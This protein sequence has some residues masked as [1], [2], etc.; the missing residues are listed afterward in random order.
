MFALIICV[1][2]VQTVPIDSKRNGSNFIRS[3][4]Q[5]L[6]ES[7]QPRDLLE[8]ELELNNSTS[9]EVKLKDDSPLDLELHYSNP[10]NFLK[11]L[12]FTGQCGMK[13]G[14]LCQVCEGDCD[15]D[16]DCAEGLAC[17]IRDSK[18]PSQ[19]LPV[20]GCETN[21]KDL[22][23]KDFCYNMT[24]APCGD[25]TSFVDNDDNEQLCSWVDNETE[26]DDRCALYGHFCRQTCG[27]CRTR[28]AYDGK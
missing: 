7:Q 10:W 28:S 26:K 4:S 15:A 20:P 11:I 17:F 14:R 27:Y 25:L 2:I 18:T 19:K 13:S 23:A 21:P 5:V 16:I 12:S 24:L 9:L 3:R 6:E 22:F 8:L 1:V